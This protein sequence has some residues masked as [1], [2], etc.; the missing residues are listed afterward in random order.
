MTNTYI[1]IDEHTNMAMVID[2]P[3]D[4]VNMIKS[5]I[6]E[7][8]LNIVG[9]LLTHSHWDHAAETADMSEIF[10]AK[11]Y[12]HKE[13]EFRL[14]K[15]NE[16]S[17]FPLPFD[18][19]PSKADVYVKDGDSIPFG[20][21]MLKVIHTPGHTD[22]SVCYYDDKSAICFCGD[23]VF[24]ESIGRIDLPGG[25][26]EKISRS[27]KEKMLIL[28]DNTRLL[29]GHGPESTIGYERKNNPYFK[30]MGIV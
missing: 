18:I 16:N 22:G 8:N 5:Y 7:Q 29:P 20:N 12:L 14:L 30:E 6:D 23:T 28:D 1:A 9:V 13:D 19:K 11:V 15:P 27:I 21:T 10:D 2:A 17:I 3:M 25:S 4:A 26:Y 24:R